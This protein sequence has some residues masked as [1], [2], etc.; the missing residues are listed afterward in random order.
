MSLARVLRVGLAMRVDVARLVVA[1][2]RCGTACPVSDE[3]TVSV[4]AP[5]VAYRPSRWV[6]GPVSPTR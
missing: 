6:S 2:V 3:V 5:V 1:R 4:R